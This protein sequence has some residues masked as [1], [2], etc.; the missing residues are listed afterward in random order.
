M[1]KH[2]NNVRK[3]ALDAI[4]KYIKVICYL[5][6]VNYAFDFIITL[7]PDIANRIFAMIF[8]KLGI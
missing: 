6:F 7:P 3:I 4:D 2:D 1:S 8:Q 5:I